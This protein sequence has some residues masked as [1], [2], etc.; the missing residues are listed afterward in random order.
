MKITHHVPAHAIRLTDAVTPEYQAEVDRST[1][2]AEMRHAVAVNK[3][4]AAEA[5]LAK[6]DGKLLLAASV[7]KTSRAAK[8]EVA[9]AAELV[10]LRREELRRIE[11][12]MKSVP[13]SLE[14]R[15]R[16][17]YRPVPP[18]GQIV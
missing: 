14:H 1:R 17:G 2:R 5:R 3:L 11:A 15:G 7:G 16:K 6:A 4:R 9:V 8:R 10:E 12:T 18:P 13:A